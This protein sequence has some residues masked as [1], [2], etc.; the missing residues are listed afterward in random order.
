MSN[1]VKYIDR[2][3]PDPRIEIGTMNCDGKTVYFIRDNGI[4]IEERFFEKVFQIFQRLPE[5]KR[6]SDGTGM[7]LTIVKRI[8]EHHGGRIWIESKPGKGTT[9]LFTFGHRGD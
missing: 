9:F 6:A 4:G 5:A 2:E 7:G 1:A 3:K 8:I